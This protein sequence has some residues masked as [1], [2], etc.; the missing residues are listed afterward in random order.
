[1]KN[2]FICIILL[3]FLIQCGN[4]GYL[5]LPEGVEDKSIYQYPPELNPEDLK[6]TKNK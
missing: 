2:N 1:M 3:F 6:E 5:V 4:T